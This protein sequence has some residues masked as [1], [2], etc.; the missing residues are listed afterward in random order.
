MDRIKKVDN[1]YYADTSRYNR[2]IDW[3]HPRF[4]HESYCWDNTKRSAHIKLQIEGKKFWYCPQFALKSN[5][6]WEETGSDGKIWDRKSYNPKVYRKPTLGLDYTEDGRL[7]EYHWGAP[8]LLD[9]DGWPI[10]EY[11]G[12]VEGCDEHEN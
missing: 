5:G 12:L 9:W 11:D 2:G 10:C 4:V 1:I 8:R 3:T 6:E 7:L